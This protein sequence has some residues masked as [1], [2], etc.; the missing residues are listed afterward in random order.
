MTEREQL[1]SLKQIFIDAN[2]WHEV[3]RVQYE[4]DSLPEPE[5]K[6]EPFILIGMFN[7]MYRLI[8]DIVEMLGENHA[9]RDLGREKL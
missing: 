5:L 8:N 3:S 7:Y 2:E 6:L 1:E 4:I 9:N